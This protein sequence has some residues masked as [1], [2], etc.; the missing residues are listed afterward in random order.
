MALAAHI[1]S[2]SVAKVSGVTSLDATTAGYELEPDRFLMQAGAA[3]PR[4]FGYLCGFP[5]QLSLEW[6]TTIGTPK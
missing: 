2:R 5:P 1:P 3:R 6:R 4:R